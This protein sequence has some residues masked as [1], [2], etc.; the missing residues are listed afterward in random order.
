MIYTS[1]YAVSDPSGA[2]NS[3]V[4]IYADYTTIYSS[5]IPTVPTK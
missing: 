4:G 3:Q 5:K 2:I 1:T